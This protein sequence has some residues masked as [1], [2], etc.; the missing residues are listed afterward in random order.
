MGEALRLA[1]KGGRTSPNPA[2]GAVIVRNRK[3]IAT[4]YHRGPGTLHAEADALK[5]LKGNARGATLYV[6]LE[7]CCHT[8]KRTPPCVE[9]II[10]AGFRKVV[11][12][13]IDP[14]P[15]VRGKGLRA[16]RSKGVK[17]E[18]GCLR[19]EAQALIRP[20][21]KWIVTGRPY[22]VLKAATSLDGK[23]ALSS[24]ESHWIT[25]EAARKKVLAL[26]ARYDAVMVGFQTVMKDDPVLSVRA[27]P[28]RDPIRVV[29]D[30]HLGLPL[31][32]K[33]FSQLKKQPTVLAT[34]RSEKNN[35]KTARFQKQGVHLVFCRANRKGR[36]DLA[37]LFRE[38]G[39]RGIAGLLVEGGAAIA[40]ALIAEN[41]ADEVQLF[42]APRVVGGS[43]L[44]LFREFKLRALKDTPW[45]FF[46]EAAF[47]GED[48]LLCLRP[49]RRPRLRK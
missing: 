26:R 15:Q 20:Y 43:G 28:G 11:V 40:S 7:P 36:V 34:L 45:F 13:C 29:L 3:I 17:V 18:E 10:A 24:G 44:D 2:V 32:R 4:G 33:V 35:P 14:N 12:G 38:L 48:F 22:V 16:L 19:P 1:R 9:A 27:S 6:S 25:G 23:I 37:D 49:R 41:R 46:E 30:S 8:E 39:N 31:N 5:K 42:V 21:A 47:I